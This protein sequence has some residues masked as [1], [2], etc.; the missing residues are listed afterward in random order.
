[1]YLFFG[2]VGKNACRCTERETKPISPRGLAS[3]IAIA[4]APLDVSR[5]KVPGTRAARA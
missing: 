1:M 4:T 2:F 5:K 3:E